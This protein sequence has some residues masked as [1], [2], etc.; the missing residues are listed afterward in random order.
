MNFKL[1]GECCRLKQQWV[2]VCKDNVKSPG[3]IPQMRDRLLTVTVMSGVAQKLLE[4]N[5]VYL[6]LWTWG[7]RCFAC[8]GAK[9]WKAY[10]LLNF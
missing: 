9:T 8:N 5:C 6:L 4:G 10:L 1:N 3:N 7:V 2:S